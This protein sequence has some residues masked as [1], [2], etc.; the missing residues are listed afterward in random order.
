MAKDNVSVFIWVERYAT[1][2]AAREA[3]K[4]REDKEKLFQQAK[5]KIA[6]LKQNLE[7][8]TKQLAELKREYEI[9]KSLYNDQQK[10]SVRLDQQNRLLSQKYEDQL[11]RTTSSNPEDQ[12]KIVELNARISLL[13][14][15]LRDAQSKVVEV[16]AKEAE[17]P[18]N[19]TLAQA[20]SQ[21]KHY[22]GTISYNEERQRILVNFI[23]Q[24]GFLVRAEISNPD[25]PKQK[26][27]FAGELI[28]N[29]EMEKGVAYQIKMNA[30]GDESDYY[31]AGDLYRFYRNEPSAL[32]LRLTDTG[33]EGEAIF[34][35][36]SIK[37]TIRLKP[38]TASATNAIRPASTTRA[39]K[40]YK[41]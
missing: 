17:S 14:K 5:D 22:I 30:V 13:E 19:Q 38:G 9:T 1:E 40:G 11:R 35:H 21:G 41:K 8:Q 25:N 31:D 26:R 3:K 15:E 18:A 28:A 10:E 4:A 12:K 33:L 2:A 6:E 7:T 37:S 16:E 32:K 29:P 27:V 20:T 39:R 23:E 34:H 24:D 36:N